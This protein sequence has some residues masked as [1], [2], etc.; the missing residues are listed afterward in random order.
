V[1]LPLPG[2]PETTT[3]SSRAEVTSPMLTA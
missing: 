3:K 2:G 1:V